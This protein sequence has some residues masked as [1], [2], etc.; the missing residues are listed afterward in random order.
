MNGFWKLLG[1]SK[2]TSHAEYALILAIIGTVIAFCGL[3][4]GGVISP[5]INEAASCISTNGTECT[6]KGLGRD[7][8]DAHRPI[9]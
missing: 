6:E 2:G 1:N 8:S 9:R 5:S 4:L 3:W 7:F